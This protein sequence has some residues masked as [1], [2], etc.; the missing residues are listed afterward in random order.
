MFYIISLVFYGVLLCTECVY[1]ASAIPFWF[2]PDLQLARCLR[3]PTA[4]R[5]KILCVVSLCAG[6]I[7]NNPTSRHIVVAVS[8]L[9]V[10]N[11]E[12]TMLHV[13]MHFAMGWGSS[14]TVIAS[15]PHPHLEE[16]SL[17]V[18]SRKSQT[19]SLWTEAGTISYLKWFGLPSGA[20]VSDTAS[21]CSM[22]HCSSWF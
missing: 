15:H 4:P 19:V 13:H 20:G 7:K 2:S 16:C 14:Y 1:A 9:K 17:P 3:A 5:A 12:W 21:Q 8:Y 10:H 11:A 6:Q 22:W 18:Y